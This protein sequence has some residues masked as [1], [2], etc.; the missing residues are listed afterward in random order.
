MKLSHMV[1]GLQRSTKVTVVACACVLALTAAVLLVL[2]FFPITPEE[3][4]VIV[5]P[6]TEPA[7]TEAEE[8]EWEETAPEIDETEVELPHTLSTWSAN[9][10]GFHRD[11]NE[12]KTVETT[13]DPFETTKKT[14]TTTKATTK[15]AA[16]LPTTDAGV[17]IDPGENHETT[18]TQTVDDPSV[19]VVPPMPT[20]EPDPQPTQAPQPVYTDP[21]LVTPDLP[22]DLVEE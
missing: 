17:P 11:V 21:P 14:T 3:R 8:L 12:F 6:S 2:M 16:T 10:N 15:E 4:T 5:A 7:A 19:V 13:R 1:N 22:P 18:Y 20:E 9:I